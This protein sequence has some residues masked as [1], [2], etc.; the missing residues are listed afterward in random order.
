MGPDLEEQYRSSKP[1]N[2]VGCTIKLK[3]QSK[4]NSGSRFI[5][6]LLK[7][8]YEDDFHFKIFCPMKHKAS[9]IL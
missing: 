8:D 5:S 1:Q 3:H 6:F 2:I 4:R 7:L 9:V